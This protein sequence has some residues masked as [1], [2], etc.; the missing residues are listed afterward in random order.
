MGKKIQPHSNILSIYSILSI[1]FVTLSLP[2]PGSLS[3]QKYFTAEVSH[4]IKLGRTK[5][6]YE[7]VSML[8]TDTLKLKIR[9]LNKP[10][11]VPNFAG[12]RHLEYHLP[13]ALPQGPDPLFNDQHFRMPA[14][15]ILPKV[16]FEGISEANV[17]AGVPDVNGDI[18][19]DFFVEIVNATFFRVYDK[20]GQAVSNLI[21]ANSIWNQVQQSSAGDPILLYDQL[22]DRWFLAEF[23]SNNRVLLAVSVTN[24]PR[25]SWDAYAFQ[26]PRFPDFPKYGIWND[27]F[28]LTTNEGGPEYP[29]YAFNRSD[30]LA[31][32]EI[33][34]FQRLTVPKNGGVF[35]EVGQPVDW[36]G[37]TPPPSG[38]PGL[39]VK[40]HDD[41][42][43]T[44]NQDHI[45]LHKIHIDWDSSANSNIEL[46]EIPT[47][48]FDTD[49][50]SL[51]NTGGFS[52]V[53]QP[54]GQ[55]I[56][57]AEWIITNKAQYRNFGTHESFVLSFM[58]DVTGLEVAGIRWMEFRK[59][60]S[61]EWHLY[62]EGTIGSDDGLHRFMSSIG[63]D[64]QGNI[65]IAYSISGF[66]K[67][68]SLR[69]TGRY[70]SDPL[71]QMTFQEYEFATGHGSLGNDRYGDYASMSVDPSDDQTFWFAGEYVPTDGNWS[72]RV[73]AF[74]ATRDTFD[75]FPVSLISP[76]NSPDLSANEA[77][78]I[79][80]LN[81]GL[82]PVTDFKLAY[83]FMNGTWVEEDALTDTLDIDSV[84]IH[85]FQSGLNFGA[86][87]NYPIRFASVLDIDRNHLNDT[88]SQVIRKPA[89]RDIALAYDVAGQQ[90]IVCSGNSINSITLRNLGVNTVHTIS[91]LLEQNGITVDTLVWTGNLLTGEEDVMPIEVTALND[92][93]NVISVTVLSVNGDSDEIESNNLVQFTL[94]AKPSGESL[95]LNLTTDNFPQE[96]T[97]ELVDS[98]NQV[99][100]SSGSLGLPQNL[101]TSFFCLDADACYSFIIYDAFGDGMS[102]QGIKGDYVILN[103]EGDTIA[104]LSKP[105]FGLEE[106]NQFCLTGGCQLELQVGVGPETT[107]GAADGFAIAQVLN[108]PGS[109]SYSID[110]GLTY[111][112]SNFFLDLVPGSYMMIAKINGE[113]CSDTI[114]FTI[115]TCNLETMVST[116]PATGGDVGEIHI[117]T[118]GGLGPFTYSLNGA[119]AVL[120]SFFTMLEPGDYLVRTMDSNGCFRN[121]SVVVSTQVSTT[122]T[123]ENHFIKIYPNPGRGVYQILGVFKNPSIFV[124]YTVFSSSGEPILHG[125]IS[126]YDEKHKGE[127]SLLAFPAGLYYAAFYIGNVVIVKRIVKA[128]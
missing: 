77:L 117:S 38:S 1:V 97:W 23:P 99:I 65:G 87:G 48:P 62:Q 125:S 75:I 43:G 71:G 92:G 74:R 25:G 100:Q 72:T 105:N 90:D 45:L 68:P 64:G 84:Y 85:T 57:G 4:A 5:P 70:K 16:N 126:K 83:Q 120:D 78:T 21:S 107:P 113:G 93:S 80:V 59:T 11:Y 10:T 124:D 53:P 50:C 28:Y 58:V 123:Q 14:N 8:P 119:P 20:S 81:R 29:I 31:G 94:E 110:G 104:S 55:G 2:V 37:M 44:T 46:I 34:Q 111:Q 42:W 12:R 49:G 52:C 88:L 101:Y 66:D 95:Y 69:Y 7:M 32:A 127:I 91:F 76:Q 41:D 39:V 79:S 82:N 106:T 33:V 17:N 3:A 96:T 36:D 118:S 40:L 13:T 35:F 26:T 122:Q 27:A 63:I 115:V 112:A 61:Q 103:E 18:S 19:R 89:M 116:L 51:E 109:V 54:N 98:L 108:V 73:V 121:D 60:S 128:G 15:E 56:D 102:A 6:L 9:K 30:L 22:A 67:H 47:A 86:P 114:D 24:D